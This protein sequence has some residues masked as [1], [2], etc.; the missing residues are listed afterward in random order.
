MYVEERSEMC[1]VKKCKNILFIIF[2][3]WLF[4]ETAAKFLKTA[5]D[6]YVRQL[7]EHFT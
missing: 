2:I 6:E 3:L 7:F 5:H 1:F 4:I